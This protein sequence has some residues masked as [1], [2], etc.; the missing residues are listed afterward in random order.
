MLNF[1]LFRNEVV[2]K[3]VSHA[4]DGYGSTIFFELG[5]LYPNK[6][7]DG[8]DGNPIGDITLM[9]EW[10]WRCEKTRSIYCGSGSSEKRRLKLLHDLKGTIVI[11][12]QLFGRLSELEIVF[13]NGLRILSFAIDQGQPDWA[14]ICRNPLA[15]TLCM[16]RG[17]LAIESLAP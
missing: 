13:S 15:T 9:I 12:I 7:D 1:E 4:W 10:N 14:I 11:D 17:K 3:K 5:N 8:S 2:G 16:K 6:R